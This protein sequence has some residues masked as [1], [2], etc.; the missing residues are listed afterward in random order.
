MLFKLSVRCVALTLLLGPFFSHTALGAKSQRAS[1]ELE[2]RKACLTKQ[3]DK[4]I[5]LLVDL[6][7]ET[8]DPTFIYNQGRCFEQNTRY[9]DAIGSFEEYLRVVSSI[10]ESE[11]A[12]VEE[13][14]AA[15]KSKIEPMRDPLS[16][17]NPA[18]DSAPASL[19]PVASTRGQAA[20]G[21]SIPENQASTSN[22][23]VSTANESEIASTLN[24]PLASGSRGLRIAAL[25]T[26]A[27]GVAFVGTGV[28]FSTKVV[29]LS[30]KL[31]DSD[32]PSAADYKAGKDA[33]TMQWIG[34]GLGAAA[35]ATGGLLY[36]FGIQ[37]SNLGIET[38][39]SVTAAVTPVVLPGLAGISAQ[40]SF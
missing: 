22:A 24:P 36:F 23:L 15:C 30:N 8:K 40:G 9:R 7:L 32:S 10:S 14:I 34:Y 17:D 3:L 39:N 28:Y 20:F 1:K 21:P 13:H 33:H 25:A 27:V 12:G 26:S 11:K 5:E 37:S 19:G 18:L 6:Y 16:P 4:G 35:L 31:T 2:A 29:S 38:S